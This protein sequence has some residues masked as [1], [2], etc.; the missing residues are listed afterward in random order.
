V[1][2]LLQRI[3]TQKELTGTCIPK[4]KSPYKGA[5]GFTVIF[6]KWQYVY[7]IGGIRMI[8]APEESI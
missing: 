3:P 1:P 8:A 7:T 2:L 4:N 6:I 5:Q